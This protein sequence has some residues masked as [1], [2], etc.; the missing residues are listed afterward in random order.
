MNPRRQRQAVIAVT[1]PR[2]ASR[3]KTPRTAVAAAR[4]AFPFL[5][6]LDAE[7]FTCDA[8]AVPVHARFGLL[9]EARR[10]SL[11]TVDRLLAHATSLCELYA[12][13]KWS[14]T[15]V[16]S[17][18]DL[19]ARHLGEQYA[20][21]AAVLARA[22]AL[23]PFGAGASMRPAGSGVPMAAR[24]AGLLDDA[25]RLRRL[26]EVHELGRFEFEAM[27]RQATI[28]GDRATYDLVVDEVVRTNER[29]SWLVAEQLLQLGNPGARRC[30]RD[31][32]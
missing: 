11:V 25:A 1:V 18:R 17:I 32:S 28:D 27:R 6:A 5:A 3:T 9:S 12:A 14:G 7:G 8:S 16:S 22:E 23:G 19:F 31:R 10:R 26:L 20:L 13:A 4:E 24:S 15:D 21:V 29:Q 2:R 30:Q